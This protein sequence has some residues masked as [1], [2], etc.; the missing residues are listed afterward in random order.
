MSNNSSIN[1]TSTNISTNDTSTN[2]SLGYSNQE[3]PSIFTVSYSSYDDLFSKLNRLDYY[4]QDN[5]F[6]NT[7]PTKSS[8]YKSSPTNST[9]TIET[10]DLRYSS[11]GASNYTIGPNSL[12]NTFNNNKKTNCLLKLFYCFK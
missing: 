1:N 4:E 5:L 12:P 2:N 8:D 6:S 10:I 7:Y 9:D 11:T 3:H